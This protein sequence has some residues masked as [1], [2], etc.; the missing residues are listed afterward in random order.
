MSSL[1]VKVQKINVVRDHPNGDKL[2]IV[3]IDGWQ[4]ISKRNEYAAGELSVFC[5]PDSVLPQNVVDTHGVSAYLAT[6]NRVKAV[7]LRGEKSFGLLL[8]PDPTWK[9]GQDV[10]SILGITKWEPPP[11]TQGL[12]GSG[13]K[14]QPAKRH[15]LW[16]R[17]TELEN[18]RHY[19][20]ILEEGEEVVATE[21]IHGC[22][23]STAMLNGQLVVS[24]RELNR[25]PPV[26]YTPR[27]LNLIQRFLKYFN[28]QWFGPRCEIDEEA[29]ATD[30]FWYPTTL[31]GVIRL[32]Q[33][34]G[35]T[36]KQVILCGETFGSVQRGMGYGTPDALQFRAFDLLIDGR[37]VDYDAFCLA[38][39]SHGIA[40]VPEIYRGPYSLE[41]IQKAASGF[42]QIEGAPKN[43][44][45]EGCVVR[46][47]K[48]RS[49]P[50][51][52]RIIFKAINDDYLLKQ[53]T[54][55]AVGD[56]KDE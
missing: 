13:S 41:A 10:A 48:E 33:D 9:E 47:V 26:K 8:K 11:P 38:C 54:K 14:T 23:Q 2:S 16:Q 21:K 44:I 34:L 53:Y 15:P 50:K 36:H 29:K 56:N 45:R 3:E 6:G 40:R 51:C 18:I 49:H 25:Q 5:P 42:T 19:S 39:D 32:L 22:N 24:S 52:G 4:I 43:Q 55:E 35:E 31:P 20:R 37:Y 46:P 27:T 17:Y 12:P 1:I 7:K 30:W 28:R